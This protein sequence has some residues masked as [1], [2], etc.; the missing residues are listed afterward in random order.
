MV[1]MRKG[2]NIQRGPKYTIE[3]PGQPEPNLNQGLVGVA[4]V[5]ACAIFTIMR[6]HHD[7]M[8]MTGQTAGLARAHGA[9]QQENYQRDNFSPTAQAKEDDAMNEYALI[10][11]YED[12]RHVPADADIPHWYAELGATYW[13]DEHGNFQYVL[14]PNRDQ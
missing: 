5:L 7:N 9:A 2:A 11:V 10:K 4:F 6:T 8:T 1:G 14:I 12:G 13:V 3:R